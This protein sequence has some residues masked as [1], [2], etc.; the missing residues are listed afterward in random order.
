MRIRT[1]VLVSS[2]ALAAA[3]GTPGT[4]EGEAGAA[5]AVD[6]F[7]TAIQNADGETA[8]DL[9]RPDTRQALEMLMA[10]AP[11]DEH[12]GEASCVYLFAELLPEEMPQQE[13][14]AIMSL[15]LGETVELDEDGETA[16]VEVVRIEPGAEEESTDMIQVHWDGERWRVGEDL[17]PLDGGGW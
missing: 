3:C 7:I 11:E 12:G 14:E 13:Q 15:E 16:E 2:V 4:A 17:I 9:M 10:W 8:C 6:A 1:C 5:D